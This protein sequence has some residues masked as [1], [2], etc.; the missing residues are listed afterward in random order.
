[1]V[2]IIQVNIKKDPDIPIRYSIKEGVKFSVTNWVYSE[3]KCI[4]VKN[5][6]L[7]NESVGE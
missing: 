2:S 7:H 3:N 5:T 6:L 1:M 4:G